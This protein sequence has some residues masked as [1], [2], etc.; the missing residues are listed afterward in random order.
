MQL[1]PSTMAARALVFSTYHFSATKDKQLY[2]F[3]I[4]YLSIC[5]SK[6][7]QQPLF[8]EIS[9]PYYYSL[10]YPLS[11]LWA[12]NTSVFRFQ[13]SLLCLTIPCYPALKN[14]N[15]WSRDCN[16]DWGQKS[17]QRVKDYNNWGCEECEGTIHSAL[18]HNKIFAVSTIP[19]QIIIPA[20]PEHPNTTQGH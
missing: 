11:I 19:W 12:N 7:Q 10:F 8:L 20:T 3:R 6:T 4:I 18:S 1:D 16:Y 13:L 14:R 2:A 17:L 15:C 9:T 5:Y